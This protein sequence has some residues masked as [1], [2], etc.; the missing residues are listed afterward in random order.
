MHLF[1]AANTFSVPMAG[2]SFKSLDS[3]ATTL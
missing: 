2:H 3:L 1:L